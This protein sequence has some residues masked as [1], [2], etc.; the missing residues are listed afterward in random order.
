MQLTSFSYSQTPLTRPYG[1]P[2]FLLPCS[3]MINHKRGHGQTV[4]TLKLMINTMKNDSAL[5]RQFYSR[6]FPDFS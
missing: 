1:K 6:T 4:Q 2:K 3:T 5:T